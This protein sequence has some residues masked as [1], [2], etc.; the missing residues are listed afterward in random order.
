MKL[1]MTL[2]LEAG[3]VSAAN[4]TSRAFTGVITDTMRNKDH[5]MKISSNTKRIAWSALR[6]MSA[7]T[8]CSKQRIGTEQAV[9]VRWQAR[10]SE[11]DSLRE[12][13]NSYRRFDSK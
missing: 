13:Q 7:S 3:S 10:A 8:G 12:D 1:S 5:G 2:I 11:G 9:P 4:Q 6:R